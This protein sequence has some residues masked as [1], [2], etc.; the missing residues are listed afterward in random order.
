MKNSFGSHPHKLNSVISAAILG[1]A[2]LLAGCDK[3]T[4]SGQTVGQKLD[5]AIDKTNANIAAAGDKVEKKVDQAGAAVTNAGASISNTT[6][7][8]I[9][10]AGDAVFSKVDQVG[11]IVDDSAITASIKADLLKDPGLSALGIEVN[12]VKGEVTLKGEV[13]TEIRKQRAEGIASHIV[14]VTRVI[15]NLKVS[16]T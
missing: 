2:L 7:S 12:T 13:S 15:N 14:G 8:A 6:G 3:Y 5:N 9:N 11:V 1:A 4:N 16:G 10:K